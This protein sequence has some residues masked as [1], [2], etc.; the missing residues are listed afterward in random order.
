VVRSGRDEQMVVGW[1]RW[2]LGRLPR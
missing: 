2:D 1:T